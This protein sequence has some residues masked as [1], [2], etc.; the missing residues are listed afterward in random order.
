MTAPISLYLCA[1]FVLVLLIAAIC[2][3]PIKDWIDAHFGDYDDIDWDGDDI[4]EQAFEAD[5][6]KGVRDLNERRG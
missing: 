5:M 6:A 2:R 4:D 1:A 3:E